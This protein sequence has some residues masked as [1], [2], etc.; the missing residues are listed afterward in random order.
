MSLDYES[1]VLAKSHKH[2]SL[3]SL[4]RSPNLFSSIHSDVWGL[5]P[6][7]A[8][9]NFSYY[10]LFVDDYTRMSLVYFLK[11]KFEVF[12]VLSPFIICFILNF[13]LNHK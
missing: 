8:T 7:S 5:A 13:M 1:C 10:V 11:H 2:S 4:S 12:S 3:P 6:N 9:H